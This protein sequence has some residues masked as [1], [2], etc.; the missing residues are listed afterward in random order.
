M[1]RQRRASWRLALVAAGVLACGAGVAARELR[2]ETSRAWSTYVQATEGRIA[3]ELRDGTRFLTLDFGLTASADRAGLRAGKIVMRK[4]ETTDA[5]GQEIDVPSGMIH[6]WAGAIFVP[7]ATLDRFMQQLRS[8]PPE[9][10][11]LD[12][13]KSAILEQGPDMTRMFLRVQRT[14][15]VTVVYNTEHVVAYRQEGP[16][17]VSS[18]SHATRIAEL[19]NPGTPSEHEQPPGQDRGF[20]WGWNSYWRY[21]QVDGGVLVECESVSMSRSIPAVIR[22]LINPIIDG[23]AR[24]SMER[25]LTAI[26]GQFEKK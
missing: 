25:T 5:R 6:H 12:V 15:I 13:L 4:V 3:R 2:A 26:R 8:T 21:E 22:Y 23:V 14:K 1:H 9:T 20:M 24:E 7:G 19:A 11:Q 18:T 17:R 10:F 16:T